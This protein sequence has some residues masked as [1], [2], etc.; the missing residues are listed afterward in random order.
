[1]VFCWSSETSGFILW[2]CGG[3]RVIWLHS[4]VV[5]LCLYCVITLC[6]LFLETFFYLLVE[7]SRLPFTGFLS[8]HFLFSIK[9][10]S[11]PACSREKEKKN[12]FLAKLDSIWGTLLPLLCNMLPLELLPSW[13]AS[14]RTS[15]VL[16]NPNQVGP[17]SSIPLLP[18]YG[19]SPDSL[20]IISSLPKKW[21]ALNWLHTLFSRFSI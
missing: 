17:H 10:C 4:R 6:I 9:M 20:I 18:S 16:P 14:D 13:P 15:T 7:V 3:C 1:V 21:W 12:L 5:L 2:S 8:P 11:S 19:C